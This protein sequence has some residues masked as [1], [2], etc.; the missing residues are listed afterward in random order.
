MCRF[1]LKELG[2]NRQFAGCKRKWE[3]TI[4]VDLKYIG[5]KV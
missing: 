4:K 1:V 3:D 5:V 2:G